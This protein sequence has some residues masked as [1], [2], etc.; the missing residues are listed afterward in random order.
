VRVTVD[1]TKCNAYANCLM[2]A[3]EV[4]DLDGASG[5][6]VVT[7]EN[8]PE[9]LR[10]RVEAAARVCPVQAIAIEG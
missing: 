10:S 6:A 7:Q 2:E 3:P 9:E 8:P 5:L 4:F 1:L